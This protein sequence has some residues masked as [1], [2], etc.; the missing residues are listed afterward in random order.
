MKRLLTRRNV[1]TWVVLFGVYTVIGLLIFEYHYLERLAS[2][3]NGRLPETFI[4]EMTG[5]YTALIMLPFV[6]FVVRRFPF[7][8]DNWYYIIPIAIA[9][10][11]VY[12]GGHTTLM[13]ISRQT[14]FPLFGLG[15]YDYGIMFYRYPMEAANDLVNFAFLWALIYFWDRNQAARKAELAAADLRSKLAEAQLENLRLQL[16]PHFLFNTLNA[17]S[18]VMYEDVRKADEMLA[19]LSDFLR[20][21]LNSSGV[22]QV[23]VA[24]ELDVERMYVDIMTTR[25]ERPMDLHVTVADAARDAVVPFMILQP[26]LENSIRHG[27]PP[28]RGAL[29]ITIDVARRGDSTVISVA[30]DGVGFA[31]P[32]AAS[33]GGGHGLTNVRERLRYMY[34]DAAAFTIG[35]RRE[36]G[37][38]AVLTF[39]FA[40]SGA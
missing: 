28:Q 21:V 12:S 7:R 22:Q 6:M 37:T 38:Q 30:D 29:A 39:P 20:T 32:A 31:A 8:R 1:V 36:G 18:S 25:L 14:L 40:A 9:C 10:E 24:E 19:K 26:L 33:N 16:N 4:E 11:I 27:Q 17:I 13:A 3:E 2:H 23:S 35:P 15:R 5:A 34:G